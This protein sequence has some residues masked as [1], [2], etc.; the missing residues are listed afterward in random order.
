MK[1]DYIITEEEFIQGKCFSGHYFYEHAKYIL[2]QIKTI[3]NMSY[4]L[5][6]YKNIIKLDDKIIIL[7]AHDHHTR[8]YITGYNKN[9]K[10]LFTLHCDISPE[11]LFNVILSYLKN[12]NI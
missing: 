9:R 8:K 5:Y 11:V 1:R 2:K 3:P 6:R 10:E 7:K 12:M 4:I